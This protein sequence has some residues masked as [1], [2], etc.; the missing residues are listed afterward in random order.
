[1]S[2]ASTT[3]IKLES[4]GMISFANSRSLMGKSHLRVTDEKVKKRKYSLK[5]AQMY[6]KSLSPKKI[7][8]RHDHHDMGSLHS[9]DPKL[10]RLGECDF[11][12]PVQRQK[13]NAYGFLNTNRGFKRYRVGSE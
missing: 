12:N 2:K 1:M 7:K 6:P 8:L 11:F 3:V 13:I 9:P 5:K 4:T 10:A